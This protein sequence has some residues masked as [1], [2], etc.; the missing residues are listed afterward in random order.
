MFYPFIR[1]VRRPGATFFRPLLEELEPRLAPAAVISEFTIPAQGTVPNGITA[2]PDGALWFVGTNSIGRVT[3]S[4]NISLFPVP[5]TDP[6][7]GLQSIT[8]GPD[9]ALWFTDPA[10]SFIGR[11][12]TSGA[13]TNLFPVTGN[14]FGDGPTDIVTGP[15]GALW[16]TNPS[17]T[18][19]RPAF[20]GS[21]GRI[22]TGGSVTKFS[23]PS[24]GS[25]PQGIAVG[26]DGALWFT[27][28]FGN[29][30]GRITTSG[31]I[32]EFTIPTPNCSPLGITTGPDGALWFTEFGGNGS[33][34]KIGRITTSGFITEFILP[35]ANSLPV[36]ITAGPDGALWFTENAVSANNIGRI[37][38]S[39][40]ITEFPIP[41]GQSE[42]VGIATG[43]DGALW[44]TESHGNKIGR[45][46][47]GGIPFGVTSI[48]ATGTGAGG[49][50]QVNV[51]NSATG[52]LIAS[53]FAFAPTFTGGVQVAVA[54]INGDGV[55]DIICAAGAGGGPQVVVIDGSQLSQV[56]SNG[57]IAASAEL[58]S[59]YAFAPTFLGGVNLAAAV[60]PSGKP[61]IVVGAGA[62]GGPQVQVI[63]ATKL[64]QVQSDGELVS[65]AIL[66]SFYAFAP[67]FAGGARVA[68]GDVLGNGTADIICAAGAGG[69][70]EVIVIDG[71]KLGQVQANG[72]IADAALLTSFFALAPTFLGGVFVTAGDVNGDGKAEVIC[73]AGSGG[74]PEVAVF[75]GSSG[76]ELNAFFALPPTFTGG[77]RL[78]FKTAFG[79]NG[80]PA[81]LTAAGPGGG[82]E[83]A[84]FDAATATNLG[85]I[86]AYP[87]T[88]SGGVFVA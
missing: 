44:F 14:F 80:K 62:G 1:P 5:S 74:G 30:I 41:T 33:G 48:F 45:L 88:F 73:G 32:S 68:L 25:N 9:G 29:R 58:A 87:P 53:F 4:G 83:V 60:T 64:K 65:S 36:G 10:S 15:E 78:G 82:P 84:P 39:G 46:S 56:Q 59:F 85:G 57:Q 76:S 81:I 49:G 2:G 27:E 77:V 79:S 6:S 17:A 72:Q 70:P 24:A 7:P 75:T 86:L 63:D 51:Y 20:S 66:A 55:P 3:T 8:T 12:T 35:T 50:P 28:E 16:F 47:S 31:T 67:T 34:N 22:T 21:I 11:I 19:G 42:P 40:A 54:D 26:P 13:I 37:S 52:T 43:S 71:R 61:E 23:V 18:S 38:T 69:G